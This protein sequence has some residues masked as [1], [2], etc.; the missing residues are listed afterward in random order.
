MQVQEVVT[1]LE[2][3]SNPENV[4]GMARF[5]IQGKRVLGISIPT[6]R[7]LAKEIGKNHTLAQELWDTGIHEARILAG[8]V[9]DPEEV[10]PAQMDRWAADF[11]SW[12]LCDQL[13]ANLFDRTPYAFAKA[14]AWSRCEPEFVRRAGFALMAALAWH[15]GH[16]ADQPF[17]EFFPMIVE[18]STDGRN[19]VKKAVSWALRQIG[20]RNPVLNRRAVAVAEQILRDQLQNGTLD[21]KRR[22]ARINEP[23]GSAT[24]ASARGEIEGIPDQ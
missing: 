24:A 3:L 13:C 11:D 22:L 7:K 2:S 20:K 16:T 12:D 4:A 5:G 8:Y 10:T 18:G 17:E 19:Y 1:T 6:L 15:D 21:S 23:Q 9:D 14:K